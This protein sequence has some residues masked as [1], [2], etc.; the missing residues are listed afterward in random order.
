MNSQYIRI[1]V[2][3]WL[4]LAFLSKIFLKVLNQK[5][6]YKKAQILQEWTSNMNRPMSVAFMSSFT[7]T[8]MLLVPN[9]AN[10]K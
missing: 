6:V 2:V 1:R 9:L 4:R 10:T 7:L 5:Y 8:L 3:V